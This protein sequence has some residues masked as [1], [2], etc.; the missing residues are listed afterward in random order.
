[1][2]FICNLKPH[3]SLHICILRVE[4]ENQIEVALTF[5]NVIIIR[6]RDSHVFKIW[7]QFVRKVFMWHTWPS[8]G[9]FISNMK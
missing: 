4:N 7:S 2:Q 8:C 6:N 3:H 9:N 5:I 1:L